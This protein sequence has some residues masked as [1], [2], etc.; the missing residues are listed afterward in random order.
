MYGI[1]RSL[2]VAGA[3]AFSLTQSAVA[4]QAAPT[5]WL[6]IGSEIG[7]TGVGV[8]VSIPLWRNHLNLTTGYSGFGLG[9]HCSIDGQSY[10]ANLRLG[11][12]PIY[13]SAYPLGPHFHLDAGIFINQT[14][15]V[16]YGEPNAAGFYVFNHRRY[17][18]AWVGQIKATTHFN[19]VAAYFGMGWGNPFF[20]S[21]RWSFMVNAG[22]ILEGG[23]RMQI[24]SANENSIRGLRR[25]LSRYQTV[26]DHDASFL[27][28][29]P[30][31]NIGLDY[32]F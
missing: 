16:A 19:P 22:A 7:T 23:A 3:F 13:L 2:I 20:G 8:Q 5:G 15:I 21:S 1:L 29:S 12:A 18:A 14:Q 4:A 24:Y 30:V 28:A 26:F 31:F 10:H 6:A 25:D 17:P 11:G 27:D 9:F 32:R